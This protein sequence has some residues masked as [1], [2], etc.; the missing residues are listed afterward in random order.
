MCIHHSCPPPHVYPGNIPVIRPKIWIKV[1]IVEKVEP[2]PAIMH[3]FRK[4][5]ISPDRSYFLSEVSGDFI[6]IF[7]FG[8]EMLNTDLFGPTDLEKAGC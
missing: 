8:M 4:Q 5:G 2:V 3:E 1:L 7:G 6:R